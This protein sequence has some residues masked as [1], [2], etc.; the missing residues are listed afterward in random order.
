MKM[1]NRERGQT[2]QEL[3]LEHHDQSGRRKTKGCVT[4]VEGGK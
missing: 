2:D 3:S 1:M 4:E